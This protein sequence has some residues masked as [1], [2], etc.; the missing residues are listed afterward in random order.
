MLRNGPRI[1][2]STKFKSMQLKGHNC[3][4]QSCTIFFQIKYL[5]VFDANYLLNVIF[6]QGTNFIRCIKPNLKMVDHLFEGGQILSQLECSGKVPFNIQ[7]DI[8][9]QSRPSYILFRKHIKLSI[10]FIVLMNNVSVSLL[11]NKKKPTERLR[12]TANDF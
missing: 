2:V 10:E 1:Q 4:N 3:Q 8:E 5:I 9:A 12:K 11:V 7:K 6:L